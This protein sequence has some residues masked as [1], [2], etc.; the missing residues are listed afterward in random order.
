MRIPDRKRIITILNT[1][2]KFVWADETDRLDKLRFGLKHSHGNQLMLLIE[3]DDN[4]N[5][6]TLKLFDDQYDSH[7]PRWAIGPLEDA[8]S[9]ES[10]LADFIPKEIK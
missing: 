2:S 5:Y 4:K 1:E 8:D 9:V 10:E 3:W 6:W 7:E